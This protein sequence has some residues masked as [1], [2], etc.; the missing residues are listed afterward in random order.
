VVG[1]HPTLTVL[2]AGSINIMVDM[3]RISVATV[4]KKLSSVA[5]FSAILVFPGS[6]DAR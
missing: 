2:L 4:M 1:R 5:C 3:L 6:C